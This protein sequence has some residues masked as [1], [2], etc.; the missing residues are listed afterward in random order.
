M[1]TAR[2]TLVLSFVA[3]LLT[4]SLVTAARSAT[5]YLV[6]PTR[7]YTTLQSV[8]PLLGAGDLV[9]VDGDHT[10]PGNVIFQNPGDSTTRIVIRGVLINGRRPV[11]SG[12][13]V[14]VVKF[15]TANPGVSPGA[16]HYTFEAFEI[17]GEGGAVHGIN[18]QAD[19]LILRDLVIRGCTLDGILGAEEG[20]GS[21][22]L[23][24]SEVYA[25]GDTTGSHHQIYMDTDETN[26][27]GSVFRMQ[28]C[29]V[30][31]AAGGHSVKSR[32]ERN[33]IYYNWIEGAGL[34]E[35]DLVGS[36]L[37]RREDSDVVGNVLKK[38]G[39]AAYV[40]RIGGDPSGSSR[41]RYRFVNN[42]VLYNY[43]V[44]RADFELESVEMHNNVFYGVGAPF[45]MMLVD[46]GQWT[47][48][49]K[50]AG[51][52]NWVQNG[53]ASVPAEW[54]STFFGTDP[55]FEDLASGDLCPSETSSLRDA[56]AMAPASVPGFAF[57]A[58]AFPPAYCPP[59]ETLL[60]VGTATRR[61]SDGALDI[62]AC[63][64]GHRCCVDVA[65][66][67]PSPEVAIRLEQ[68]LPNAVAV[69]TVL[70]FSS[71]RRLP[72]RLTVFDDSGRAVATVLDGVVG[73]GHHAVR[74]NVGHLP[75]G[76]Y[77]YRLEAA[78]RSQGRRLVVLR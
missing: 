17:S 78:G 19:D 21:C 9:L 66:E 71:S 33:E 59:R 26:H 48:G 54:D 24:Y 22:L 41:G 8:A 57:P 28:F 30:H 77:Y 18:H 25:C 3:A 11:L 62:G 36:G 53:V 64:Y 55:G 32:A 39:A 12:G 16:D 37:G 47:Q 73:P 6:G 74:W 38:T 43:R 20:S 13:S 49:R 35:L 10:Y 2:T 4:G 52:K 76:I 50:V 60:A 75:N 56:A 65:G 72:A 68:N 44:F 51:K 23:E 14:D 58:P 15:R 46:A 67:A 31:D 70:R 40:A 27:P 1:S 7:T 61:Y 34:Q 29:Y 69:E 45:P 63:E 42:T 5:T